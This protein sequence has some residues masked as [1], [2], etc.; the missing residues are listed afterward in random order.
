M[1]KGFAKVNTEVRREQITQAAFKVIAAHGVQGLTTSAI[2]REVGISGAN[3]YRHFK[4]KDEILGSVADNIGAVLLRNLEAVQRGAAKNS[5]TRLRKLFARHLE[6]IEKCEGIPRLIF[7][8]EIHVD[9]DGLKEKLL[10]AIASYID[11]TAALV[12]EGQRQG[13]INAHIEARAAALT[14]IGMIQITVMRWSLGSF[15]FPLVKEGMKLWKNFETC[16]KAGRDP[17]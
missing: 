12:R 13:A 10:S 17:L 6:Y 15:S 14:M 7:S 9:N 5:L 3:L 11:G 16:I 2:A 8:E 1:L 4:N